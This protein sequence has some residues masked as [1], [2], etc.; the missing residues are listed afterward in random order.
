[1]PSLQLFIQDASSVATW[2]MNTPWDDFSGMLL[3]LWFYITSLFAETVDYLAA[4]IHQFSE[5]IQQPGALLSDCYSL[6]FCRT[7]DPTNNLEIQILCL[8][9]FIAFWVVLVIPLL[10]GF[11]TA[12]V[13]A[14]GLYPQASTGTV[15]SLYR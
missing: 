13:I 8:V 15:G 9:W 12:G 2:T 11:G 7:H 3:V 5:W 6:L 1:M 14:G 10:M 4:G